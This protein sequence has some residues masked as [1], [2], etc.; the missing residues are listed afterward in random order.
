MVLLQ[1]HWTA[2]A[3]TCKHPLL[4]SMVYCL[5]RTQVQLPWYIFRDVKSV[6]SVEYKPLCSVFV[7]DDLLD[8]LV[9]RGSKWFLTVETLLQVLMFHVCLGLFSFWFY[10]IFNQA[11]DCR[12][13]ARRSGQK[14]FHTL[15]GSRFTFS[16]VPRVTGSDRLC[17]PCSAPPISQV[18]QVFDWF[19]VLGIL[20][21]RTTHGISFPT[22]GNSSYTK[23][24]TLQSATCPLDS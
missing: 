4:C 19:D 17:W 20:R 5:R 24:H 23:I 16:L 13:V 6:G 3:K 22:V 11:L 8:F 12:R 14:S 7:S 9:R 21:V 15:P 18:S 10:H 2:L 1:R